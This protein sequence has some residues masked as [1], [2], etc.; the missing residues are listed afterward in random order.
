MADL[1]AKRLIDRTPKTSAHKICS[2]F[3]KGFT[4][5]AGNGVSNYGKVKRGTIMAYEN[6]ASDKRVRP[7]AK[8]LADGAGSSVATMTVDDPDCFYVGDALFD[9]GVA[10]SVTVTDKSG[11]DL[12]LS[13]N[14]SWADNSVI[15]GGLANVEAIGVLDE[16]KPT[17]HK[18]EIDEDGNLIHRDRT[19]TLLLIGAVAEDEVT[20]DVSELAADLQILFL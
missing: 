14:A 9:D 12:I 2:L 13:G 11:S 4:L 6:P 8:T 10:L 18:D 17:W 5:S 7:A 16:D 20:G 15:T 1:I 3:E 19:V